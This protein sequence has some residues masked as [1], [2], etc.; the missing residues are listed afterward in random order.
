M[1]LF[2]NA[3]KNLFRN[4]GRYLLVGGIITVM[5]IAVT[6]LAMINS[7]TK[8]IINDYVERFSARVYFTQDMNVRLPP[9]PDGYINMN[10]YDLTTEELLLF[11]DSEYLAKTMLTGEISANSD[12]LR[13]IDEGTGTQDPNPIFA[14][15]RIANCSVY[16]YSDLSLIEEFK[17]NLR[18]IVVGRMFENPGECVISEELAELNNLSVGDIISVY[19]IWGTEHILTLTVSGI[20]RDNTIAQPF[21]SNM[22]AGSNRRNDILTSYETLTA[23][24]TSDAYIYT[25][26]EYYLKNPDLREA[27]EKELRKKGLSD[28]WIVNVDADSY[29]QIV[30][31]VKGLSKITNFMMLVVLAFGGGVLILLSVLSV[32][33]RKY[34]IGVLRAMGMEKG[35]VAA[36]MLIETFAVITICLCL[37]LGVGITVSQPVSNNI[38]NE[39]ISIAQRNFTPNEANYGTAISGLR[40]RDT[41][42]YSELNSVNVRVTPDMLMMTVL[43]AFMLGLLSNSVGILY[44]TRFEPIRILS[45]RD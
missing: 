11:A 30:E 8:E 20:Y 39:Q 45:E 42:D 15:N 28:L 35:K 41:V 40:T 22:G 9:G 1:Y 3:I 5:L 21:G 44:I 27:F 24:R 4:K 6:V 12:S 10:D 18:E 14:N 16:G 26:A 23:T 38:L 19:N 32:R 33:E 25:K 2:Q 43:I 13:F 17:L 7:T 36:G 29:S 37:G 31:P 34:E